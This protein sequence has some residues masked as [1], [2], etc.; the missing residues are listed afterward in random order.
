MGIVEFKDRLTIWISFI[1]F[2][3]ITKRAISK[4]ID[5]AWNAM[6]VAT[7]TGYFGKATVKTV[8]NASAPPKARTD[9]PAVTVGFAMLIVSLVSWS[10]K[11]TLYPGAS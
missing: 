2:E 6:T 7:M 10:V 9:S 1:S 11:V 5:I 3:T 8:T 4:P